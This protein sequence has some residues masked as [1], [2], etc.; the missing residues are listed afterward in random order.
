[1]LN[2]RDN[3]IDFMRGIV[4]ICMVLVHYSNYLDYIVGNEISSK[5]IGY[6]DV[7]M[8]GFIYLFGFMIGSKYFRVFKINRKKIIKRL[9]NR[10]FKFTAIHYTMVLTIGMPLAFLIGRK[11]TRGVSIDKYLIESFLFYNQE[12]LL[13]ILPTFISLS[14]SGSNALI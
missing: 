10:A 8:E 5:V 9:F 14:I 6:T 13:H 1:M 4:I 3:V 2:E 12:P 7:A 11:L